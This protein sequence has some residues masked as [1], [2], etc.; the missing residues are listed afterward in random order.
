MN[1]SQR[2]ERL[3]WL[4]VLLIGMIVSFFISEWK[5]ESLSQN[6][7]THAPPKESNTPTEH[8]LSKCFPSS[9]EQPQELINAFALNSPSLFHDFSRQ[10]LKLGY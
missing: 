10:N 1:A 8:I 3:R 2:N 9:S 7:I 6:N 4:L 5:E